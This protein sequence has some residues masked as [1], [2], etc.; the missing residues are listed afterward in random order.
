M[1]LLVEDGR[2]ESLIYK[3]DPPAEGDWNVDAILTFQHGL[4]VGGI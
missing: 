4:F 3:H 1:A 2:R